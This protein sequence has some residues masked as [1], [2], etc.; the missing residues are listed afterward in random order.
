MTQALFH[1]AGKDP[2]RRQTFYKFTSIAGFTLCTAPRISLEML[3]RPG[4]VFLPLTQF[5]ALSRTS[6]WVNS[7]TMSFF[8]LCPANW[9][10]SGKLEGNRILIIYISLSGSMLLVS[11]GPRSL[12]MTRLNGLPLRLL[13]TDVTSSFQHATLVCFITLP[14]SYLTWRYES[15]A[16]RMSCSVRSSLNSRS[17]ARAHKCAL[18]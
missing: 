12:H 10:T 1:Y 9:G 11:G 18:L 2:E 14:K 17:F 15:V 4:A 6:S 8:T 3:S 7:G 13:L 5:I 16:A